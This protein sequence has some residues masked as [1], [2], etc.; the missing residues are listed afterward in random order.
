M[1]ISFYKKKNKKKTSKN[2]WYILVTKY[3]NV[4]AEIVKIRMRTVVCLNDA[5]HSLNVIFKT[6][7]DH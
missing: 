7:L 5:K 2:I 1:K 6:E 4:F 3:M